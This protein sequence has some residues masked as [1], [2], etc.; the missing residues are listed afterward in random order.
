MG[1]FSPT[2]IL[3][4][5][6]PLDLAITDRG[7]LNSPTKTVDL[8]ISC[9]RSISLGFTHFEALLLDAHTR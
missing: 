6:L 9:I 7:V 5:L 3:T 1:L 8:S 4:D 2:Y